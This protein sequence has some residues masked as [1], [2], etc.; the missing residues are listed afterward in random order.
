MKTITLFAPAKVNLTLKVLGKRPDGYYNLSTVFE[1]INLCDTMR[2]KPTKE[3]KIR[4]FCTHP[5]VPKGPKNLA[6]RAA[7]FLQNDFAQAS[8][9]DIT[10]TKRIPVA[11][12]LAGGSSNA[13][14]TLLG[15]NQVWNLGLSLKD[16]IFYA[17]QIGAD[18]PFFIYKYKYALGTERGDKL[19]ELKIGQKY[20][21][22]VVVSRLKV[23][24]AE[25][26]RAFKMKLT[27]TND[28]ANILTRALQK[29]SLANARQFLAN[30][31]ETAIVHVHPKLLTIKNNISSIINSP[32]SFSGSGPSIFT[33]VE[34][35]QKA[36]KLKS[37][38]IVVG[39]N[40]MYLFLMDSAS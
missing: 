19:K 31:L 12:G 3:K 35:E 5:G 21:H 29:G 23:Y 25:V 13:A 27:K 15:L 24:S 37:L 30:D 33:L 36:K 10:I 1:K 11:A 28:N 40:K 7:K 9:V 18:V 4:I 32:V 39:H 38:L 20:W 26:F 34:S 2:F 6:Y 22:I 14:A 8:G 16:M 17:K